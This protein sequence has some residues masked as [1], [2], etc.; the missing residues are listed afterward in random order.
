MAVNF[1]FDRLK[2]GFGRHST[3]WEV[4]DEAAEPNAPRALKLN[5]ADVD[6]WREEVGLLARLRNAPCV[7]Q[8][9]ASFEVRGPDGTH[10][11]VSWDPRAVS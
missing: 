10:G 9:V 8:I 2:L 1:T 3:V 4:V 7:V 11:C 5:R 6:W